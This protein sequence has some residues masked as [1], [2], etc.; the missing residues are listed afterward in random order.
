MFDTMSRDER[1]PEPPPASSRGMWIPLIVVIA[2]LGALAIAPI[3][4]SLRARKLRAVISDV[5]DPARLRASD[6]EA[7]FAKEM[8]AVGVR[9]IASDT[10]A[11]SRYRVALASERVDALALDSLV[12]DLGA[13]GIERLALYREAAARWHGDVGALA[14]PRG[15]LPTSSVEADGLATLAAIDEL[16]ALFDEFAHAR[17]I[18]ARQI[19][20]VDV[21]L[22]AA[23]F[24][25][26][27]LACVLV[28]LA[29][30]RTVAISRRAERDRRALAIA[31]E[32]KN[33]FMRGI[34]HDLQNPLGAAIGHLALL[35]DGIVKPEDERGALLRISR[36]LNTVTETVAALLSVARSE[37]GELPLDASSI[38]LCA[39]VRAAVDDHGLAA[40]S[41]QQ[42]VVFTGPAECHAIA[43]PGRVRHI[44][45]NLLS[46]SSKYTPSG[47]QIRIDI[48][49]RR[50]D[51]RAWT[52]LT[53][54]DS[55]PGIPSEWRERVFKEFERVPASRDLAPG[56]GIGL[57]VSRRVAR[58]MGG[59]LMLDSS[60]GTAVESKALSGATFTL[61]LMTADELP[62]R[63]AHQ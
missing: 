33:I 9:P 26:A 63:P 50:R 34:T 57:A 31:M 6:L 11:A 18:E 21:F 19:E 28:I 60:D 32:Q 51:N 36:L 53:V 62:A 7:S 40:E 61:W 43:D 48:G 5:V 17:R 4:V 1:K 47:G 30:R 14:R 13:D 41:K 23:L 56:N 52:T 44:V 42:H 59:D 55:G 10:T 45:D 22:P 2:V 12:R 58:M 49:R 38:D 16:R 25:L 46:N 20:L 37:T 35:I 29:G 8:F 3:V 15:T 27:L 54:Q 39:L 24:P